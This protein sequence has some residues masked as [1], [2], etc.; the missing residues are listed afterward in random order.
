VQIL[1][2][3]FECLYSSDGTRKTRG[4]QVI[5]VLAEYGRC[6]YLSAKVIDLLTYLFS[7]TFAPILHEIWAIYSFTRNVLSITRLED[8]KFFVEQMHT[9]AV[10]TSI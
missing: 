6:L 8:I 10:L 4:L 5:E 2:V 9:Y 1:I 3:T 7:V